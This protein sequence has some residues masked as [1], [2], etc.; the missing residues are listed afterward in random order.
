MFYPLWIQVRVFDEHLNALT[1]F[2]NVNELLYGYRN[3]HNIELLIKYDRMK[4]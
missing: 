4:T 2:L 1:A 3:T